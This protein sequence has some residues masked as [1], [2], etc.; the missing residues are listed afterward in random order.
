MLWIQILEISQLIWL[1]LQMKKIILYFEV[2]FFLKVLEVNPKFQPH[3]FL[4]LSYIHNTEN[5]SPYTYVEQ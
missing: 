5:E 1:I 3:Q 4:L 2:F